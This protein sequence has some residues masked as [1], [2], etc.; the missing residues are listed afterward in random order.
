SACQP[1]SF[2]DAAASARRSALDSPVTRIIESEGDSPEM[3]SMTIGPAGTRPQAATLMART[4]KAAGR[5][6]KLARGLGPG[7]WGTGTI[8]PS[9]RLKPQALGPVY[10]SA[11]VTRL[12]ELSV[13]FAMDTAWDAFSRS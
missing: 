1:S 2:H 7:A 3:A 5:E 11:V 6:M 10:G 12:R 4:K 8:L 13:A 9:P